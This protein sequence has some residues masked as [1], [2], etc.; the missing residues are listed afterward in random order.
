MAAKACVKYVRISPSKAR[1]VINLV[2]GQNVIEA[3]EMLK[4]MNKKA[5]RP[6]RKLLQAAAANAVHLSD[7]ENPVDV[8][9][10]V[11]SDI[12]ANEGPTMKRLRERALGRANVIRKRTTHLHVEVS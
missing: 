9:S 1:Q 5:A 4:H 6:V 7:E 8:D 10:L 3:I 2:R 12:Y 11:V